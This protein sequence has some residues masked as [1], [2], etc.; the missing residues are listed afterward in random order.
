MWRWAP[1]FLVACGLLAYGNSFEGEFVY[2]SISSIV[3]N[4]DIRQLWPPTWGYDSPGFHAATN[5]RPLVGLSLA[6]NYAADGLAIGGY[7]LFNLLVHLLAGLVLYGLL[8]RTLG[9]GEHGLALC[10]ALLWILHP[11][12]NQCI[13]YVLQ[14]SESLMG[15]FYLLV[16]YAARRGMDGQGRHWYG[17]ALCFSLLGMASK[18]VMAT[19]P[20]AVLLYDRTFVAG[21][22]A[23]SWH[24][25]RWWYGGLV[26]TT[27]PLVAL[28]W[29]QPHGDSIGFASGTGT[30]QYLLNQTEILI[31]YLSKVVWPSPLLLDYGRPVQLGLGD[32]WLQMLLVVGL[33]AATLWALW[34][35]PRIGFV[36]AWFFLLLAPTSSFVPMMGE[37]GAERRM[38]LPLVGV[39]AL[40]VW[41]LRALVQRW[42]GPRVWLALV[43]V[44]AL[45]LA[46]TTMERNRDYHSAVEVW[47]TAIEG[48]P[49]NDRAHA[50]LANALQQEGDFTGAL[51]HYERA[52]ELRSAQPR[53]HYNLGQLLEGQ[54]KEEAAESAYR[55]VVDLE[56]GY[57][58]EPN[59]PGLREYQYK[60]LA[61][62]FAAAYYKLARALGQRREYT[63]ATAHLQR[64]LILAPDHVEAHND[65]GT[66]LALQKDYRGAVF[67]YEETLRL[68]PG[69]ARAEENLKRARAY[70]K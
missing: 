23:E 55:R 31:T 3:E 13:N 29:S 67:H 21:S 41:C 43:G 1:L 44:W 4:K 66:M 62:V 48:I 33:L 42:A 28:Q 61:P 59:G 40:L 7:R 57:R 8:R 69:Y 14:R 51:R 39:L 24:Q 6:F 60:E 35:W 65:L 50:N 58:R 45:A 5:S 19:V 64:A 38:Y 49:N 36:A 15:L 47:E 26:M 16:L 54:K 11:L 68:R 52:V 53:V 12:N 56:I 10:I 63:V 27:I 34:F 46:W 20:L 32:V 18:E 30:W 2:D 25:R 70:L 17:A 22:F 9:A 37:V